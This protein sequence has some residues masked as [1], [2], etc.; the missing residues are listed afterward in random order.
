MNALELIGRVGAA[1]LRQEL[2]SLDSV[3][4]GD[5]VRFLLDLL[6][7]QQ[8]AAIVNACAADPELSAALE[9]RIPRALGAGQAISDAYLT[10]QS[11]VWF[12]NRPPEGGKIALLLASAQDDRRES[13]AEL[14]CLGAMD[15][16]RA[17]DLWVNTATASF[18][19]PDSVRAVLTAALS[20]LTESR[21]GNATLARFS[22]YVASVCADVNAGTVPIDALGRALPLLRLPRDTTA[23]ATLKERERSWKNAWKRRW[24]QLYADR[25][26]LLIKLQKNRQIIERTD[27]EEQFERVKDEIPTQHHATVASFIAAPPQWCP[28]AEAFS[29]IEWDIEH[30]SQLFTG[31][32]TAREMHIA[33]RTRRHFEDRDPERLS[34]EDTAYLQALGGRRTLKDPGPEDRSFHERHSHFLG[35]D[36]ALKSAWDRFIYGTSVTCSDLLVGLLEGVERLYGRNANRWGSD[37]RLE[38]SV[39]LNGRKPFRDIN[40]DAARLFLCRYKG[41]ATLAGARFTVSWSHLSDYDEFL[42]EESDRGNAPTRSDSRKANTIRLALRLVS[43]DHAIDDAVQ[44]LWSARPD[45]ISRQLSDDLHRLVRRPFLQLSVHPNRI[46]SKG[47]LQRVSLIDRDTLDP[48]FGKDAGALVPSRD[49]DAVDMAAAWKQGIEAGVS[50]GGVTAEHAGRLR[51]AWD[52]FSAAYVAALKDFSEGRVAGDHSVEQAAAYGALLKD[53]SPLLGRDRLRQSLIYPLLQI[54]VVP[55]QGEFPAAIIAPWHP[56]RLISAATKLRRVARFVNHVL[57]SD[58]LKFGDVGMFFQDFRQYLAHPHA[59][60]IC[61]TD[62]A[63]RPAVLTVVNTLDDYSLAEAPLGA[64]NQWRSQSDP[65]VSAQQLLETVDRYLE[66]QP[67]ELA[68]LSIALFNCDSAGLPTAT[69]QGLAERQEEDVHCNVILRHTDVAS[70]RRVYT[71][72]I[73]RADADPDAVIASESSKNF[74]ANLRVGIQLDPPTQPDANDARS[75]DIAFLDDVIARRAH[76]EFA[77]LPAM[78][79]D[80]SFDAYSPSQRSYRVPVGV[81]ET[82]AQQYLACPEQTPPGREYVRAVSGAVHPPVGAGESPYSIPVRRLQFSEEHTRRLLADAH[83]LADWVVNYDDVLDPR[84]LRNQDIQVIRFRRD[85]TSGRNLIISSTAPT[86]LLRILVQRRLA[87]LGTG[88]TEDELHEVAQRFI[89]EATDI[90]GEIVIRAAKRGVFAGELIGIVLSRRLIQE[91]IGN[92]TPQS[93]FFLDDY[94]SWLGRREGQ[95]ADL[96]ALSPSEYEGRPAV[97][98][99]ASEAKYV[100]YTA[101]SEARKKSR[102]QIEETVARLRSALFEDPGRLDRDLWLSRLS[103]LLTDGLIRS[104]HSA[105]WEALPGLLRD[106]ESVL[107]VRGYSHIFVSGPSDAAV[108][109]EQQLL[110]PSAG[111]GALQEVFSPAQVRELILRYARG[112]SL[113]PVRETLG[114]DRPWETASFERLAAKPQWHVGRPPPPKSDDSGGGPTSGCGPSE[115]PSRPGPTSGGTPTAA[116]ARS[117]DIPVEQYPAPA[118]DAPVDLSIEDLIASRGRSAPA[119]SDSPWLAE[120]V[121]KLRRA[122]ATY[123]L[124]STVIGS[125]LTPNTA[126]IRLQ[127]SDRLTVKDIEQRR[128][129]LLTTHGLTIVSTAARPGEVVVSVARPQREVISLWDVWRARPPERSTSRANLSLLIGIKELDGDPLLLNLTEPPSGGIEHA[130]HTLI[131]GTTGSGKSVLIQNLLLDLALKNDPAVVKVTIIDPKMGVDYFSLEHLPHLSEPVITT[132]ERALEVLNGLV[133]EMDRRYRLFAGPRVNKLAA[134][135]ERVDVEARLPWLVVVHDEFADW[136]QTEDYRDA[137]TALVN[138]LSVKARAAGIHLVF[139][140]QRPDVSVMPMQLRDNL[141]NRLILRVEAEGTSEFTLNERGAERLLGRGHIACRLQGEEIQL[142]QV[143]WMSP[144]DAEAVITALRVG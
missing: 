134:F 49:G 69:V 129:Q 108:Q 138:R 41:L 68:N 85:T 57:D 76:L 51:A 104:P 8:I 71:D 126:L 106:G 72:L 7:P 121:A 94:A 20:G 89:E 12:R 107:D 16:M 95:I 53:L 9:I 14:T 33:E 18:D 58:T 132:Q 87:E 38:L 86:G 27:L 130:P 97:V 63:G 24:E 73:E 133:A 29:E 65:Q 59:P 48:V 141:G 62:M 32:K 140:A 56:L 127:G 70:L 25:A 81:E 98:V 137:V 135:N 47:D 22:S 117:A 55:I 83:N 120:T 122:L 21:G 39:D 109:G 3:G 143:P 61:V 19:I 131:A 10:D 103:E 101:L 93:W 17:V 23:F 52:R 124:Q 43:T 2:R 45:A 119:Q 125:R 26:S 105:R 111:E 5:S 91:E 50:R 116:V 30:S 123:Q 128:S 84:Q 11:T 96:L 142:A 115:P 112:Q 88:L 13:L 110:A 136:M 35:E 113:T 75:V 144:E 102:G 99:R 80:I 100:T 139:A 44:I 77:P 40:E 64:P 6:E 1:W 78:T 118:L 15:L 54:G 114:T 92:A 79:A 46:S 37:K 36:V 60:E 74:M 66:L 4:Q 34:E 67:H 31:L 90:S 28:E 42:R 82:T